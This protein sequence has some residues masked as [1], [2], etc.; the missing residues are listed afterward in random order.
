MNAYLDAMMQK[1][2]IH[3]EDGKWNLKFLYGPWSLPQWLSSLVA[4]ARNE[5]WQNLN[6]NSIVLCCSKFG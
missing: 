5:Q 1:C 6:S 2:D 3:S 4:K